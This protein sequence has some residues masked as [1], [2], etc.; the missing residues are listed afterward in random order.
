[1]MLN[2]TRNN[3]TGQC[4]GEETCVPSSNEPE[5]FTVHTR[6]PLIHPDYAPG[7]ENAAR[8]VKRRSTPG[9]H[10]RHI[11]TGFID[12]SGNKSLFLSTL[13]CCCTVLLVLPMFVLWN[14]KYIFSFHGFG[15]RPGAGPM[16]RL[17]GFLSGSFLDF[18]H[19]DGDSFFFTDPDYDTN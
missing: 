14:Q 18:C 15:G 16:G 13:S 6:S 8:K 3:R 5:A 11:Q 9:F 10:T 17:I 2:G 1:M 19:P 7:R 12:A 4:L